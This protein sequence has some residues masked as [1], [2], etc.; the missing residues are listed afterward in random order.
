LPSLGILGVEPYR[1]SVIR[2][3]A[4]I[5]ALRR[6]GEPAIVPRAGDLWIEPDRLGIIGNRKLVV[7]YGYWGAVDQKC[8]GILRM[9]ASVVISSA[10]VTLFELRTGGMTVWSNQAPLA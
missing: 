2:Y 7:V 9:L 4:I 8:S 5:V 10:V 1:L 6:M 3:G